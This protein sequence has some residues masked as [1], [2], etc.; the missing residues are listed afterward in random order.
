M[1][2]ASTIS[3]LTSAI[4]LLSTTAVGQTRGSA[5]DIKVESVVFRHADEMVTGEG[6]LVLAD[7]R[8]F[9]VMAFLNTVGYDDEAQGQQMHPIRIKVRQLVAA[10]L[11]NRPEKLQ[12]WRKY[13]QS[14]KFKNYHFQDW[15][16]SLSADY[17][18]K[19]IRPSDE[20]Q[21]ILTALMLNDFPDVL[22]DFWVTANLEQVWNAVKPDYI[23]ELK[24]YNFERMKRQLSFLW[25]YLRMKRSDTYVIVNVPDPIDRHF[26]SIGARYEN[27]YYSVESPGASGY[28]LN[29]HE[30]LHSIVNPLVKTNYEKYQSKLAAYYQA[31]KDGPLSQ[32]YQN[33]ETFVYECLVRALDHRLRIKLEARESVTKQAEAQIAEM[34]RQGLTLTRP[35]YLL[36]EDYEKSGKRFDEYMPLLFDA[37]PKNGP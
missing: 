6:F 27:Y 4:V 15:A 13:Y 19:R 21:Y 23:A 37:L 33:L 30:Y 25:E 1:K 7:R 28:D 31:G 26:H 2:R 29:V 11:S 10:N 16:L 12:A 9:A 36:L 18:F 32:S 24:K 8:I 34:T 35:F 20:L 3:L 5:S 22:N 17:P 14:N